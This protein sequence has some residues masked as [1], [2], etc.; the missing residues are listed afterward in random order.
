MNKS[1]PKSRLFNTYRCMH[2]QGF[3]PIFVESQSNPKMLIEACVQAGIGCIEYT[4]RCPDADKMIPWIG[5]NYPDIYLLAGSTLDNDDIIRRAKVKHPQLLTLSELAQMGV[6]G[7]VSMVGWKLENIAKYA[8]THI[9]CPCGE[10]VREAFLQ[11]GA[12]SHFIKILGPILEGLKNC[13][14]GPTFGACPIMIT[15]GMNLKKIDA[16][17]EAG[18]VIIGTGFDLLL[19]NQQPDI[20]PRKVTDI[21][22]QYINAVKES[23]MKYFPEMA[24][25][26][27]KDADAWLHSLPHIHPFGK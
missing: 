25:T 17:V 3:I 18:A 10:T 19:N 2:E 24:K 23:R 26:I 12:G 5:Q 14:K 20:S 6:D 9:V 11:L 8:S 1:K 4:L 15:G 22:K 13:R 27:G 21:L 7:F 16:A